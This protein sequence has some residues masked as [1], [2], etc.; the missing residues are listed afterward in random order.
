M[1]RAPEMVDLYLRPMLTEKTDIWAL[2]CMLYA[3]C[4]L[5]HPFQDGSTL[6]ILN[7]KIHFPAGSPY[8][9]DVHAIIL[10]LLDVSHIYPQRVLMS[11]G[12]SMSF[13]QWIASCVACLSITSLRYNSVF[14]HSIA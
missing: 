2:G 3:M 9:E 12:L 6:G 5:I 8:G 13:T 4:F 10:R 11:I 14:V 1:Y 7:A